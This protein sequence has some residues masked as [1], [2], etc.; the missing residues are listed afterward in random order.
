MKTKKIFLLGIVFSLSYGL[1]GLA[2]YR[3]FKNFAA[4]TAV[5]YTSIVFIIKLNKK[6][7]NESI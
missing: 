2:M 1:I 5:F 4:F 7:N 6:Q 3:D